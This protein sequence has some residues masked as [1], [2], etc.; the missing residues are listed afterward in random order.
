MVIYSYGHG[1]LFNIA[2]MS[3]KGADGFGSVP[4]GLGLPK[5]KLYT[6]KLCIKEFEMRKGRTMK[7]IISMILLLCMVF[8]LAACGGT[9]APAEDAA[10]APAEA[11]AEEATEAPA[12]DA[13]TEATY[14][15][16][17]GVVSNFDSSETGNAQIDTTFAAIVTDAE[18][19]IVACRIDCAQNKMDVTD[20]V[21]TT[22]NEYPTKMEKGDAYG[23]VQFG[24]AI[25]EWDD[26][27]KAFEQFVVGKT[28]EEVAAL[29]TVLNETGHNV[30]V[31]ETLFASCTMDIVDFKAAVEKAGSDEW[32]VTFTTADPFT[33]GVAAITDDA[34]S[35]APTA[36]E[37]GVVKMY[38]EFG[39]AV[40]GADG[41]I[42]AALNDAI[43]PNITVNT[44]GEI[45][46]TEYK[47]T[48]RE[49][50]DD[51]GMVQ[52]GAAIAEWDAQS[53]AFS[54]YTVGKT[55]DEVASL[56]T[57]LNDSGHNVSVDETL[58]ASCTM[59]ITGMMA[60]ISTAANYAR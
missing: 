24:N 58:L 34:D 16:G 53:A 27:T 17:M 32:A 5:N 47:G 25:A 1:Y 28:V 29:E 9:E 33:V 55:A 3:P 14:T 60:V 37:D 36:E 51:Y 56:E 21:V 41:T 50:G 4:A 49:L 26:Q 18:G 22:G 7:K 19:K 39:A 57:V 48:K 45:V 59:D 38:T 44:A 43:Q 10:E 52:F 15:L 23:M 13:G 31:D 35:T 12:E 46:S 6:A 30:A 8:A 2:L 54:Q 20:G 11:P 40:V 42:L